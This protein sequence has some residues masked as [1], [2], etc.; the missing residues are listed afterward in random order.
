MVSLVGLRLA[1]SQQ[2]E[3]PGVVVSPYIYIPDIHGQ[4]EFG[5]IANGLITA[6]R[7]TFTCGRPISS[8]P[9]H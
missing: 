6:A 1:L 4:G 2:H 7:G 9:Q 8:H 3:V 5:E